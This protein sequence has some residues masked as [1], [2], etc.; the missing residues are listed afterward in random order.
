MRWATGGQGEHPYDP[1]AYGL[2]VLAILKSFA[3]DAY[4]YG[5]HRLQCLDEGYW[6]VR[7]SKESSRQRVILASIW[8]M[9]LLIIFKLNA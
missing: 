5:L 3:N 9:M 8:Q 7:C 6:P 1:N 2:W 4:G